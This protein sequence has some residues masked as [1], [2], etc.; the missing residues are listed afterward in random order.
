MIIGVPKESK[1]EEYR[2]GITPFGVEELKRDGHTILVETGAG[3][4]SGFSDEE[5]LRAAADVVDR[6][7]VF[8]QSDLVVKVKE[9]L[10]QEFGP[11]R[12]GQAL[13]TFLHLAPKRALTL[14]LLARRV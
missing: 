1:K 2:V 6:E 8:K 9:P 11:I 10:L 3:V 13:F 5:Y 7:T 4:G 12:A 14:M